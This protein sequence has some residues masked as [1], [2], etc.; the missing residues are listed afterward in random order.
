MINIYDTVT[1]RYLNYYAIFG[2]LN[3]PI[4]SQYLIIDESFDCFIRDEMKSTYDINMAGTIN[5]K[6]ED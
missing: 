2:K 1:S 5:L 6:L 4:D 3:G